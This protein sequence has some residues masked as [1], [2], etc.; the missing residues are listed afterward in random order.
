[1]GSLHCLEM[2]EA[3][4]NHIVKH[5]SCSLGT[6]LKRYWRKH[7][8]G[9]CAIGRDHQMNAAMALE[10]SLAFYLENGYWVPKDW[11]QVIKFTYL[12]DKPRSPVAEDESEI[13]ALGRNKPRNELIKEFLGVFTEICNNIE[14]SDK[15]GD[16]IKNYCRNDFARLEWQF[17]D[18]ADKFEG[19][20]MPYFGVSL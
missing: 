20:R 10:F 17:S 11:D 16:Y 8:R 13:L 4:I 3:M 12:S 18:D 1:M 6:A 15:E 7:H 2:S 19:A 5:G 14:S 9:Y